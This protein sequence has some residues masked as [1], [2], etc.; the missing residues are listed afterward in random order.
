MTGR[1]TAITV[2]GGQAF[3]AKPIGLPLYTLMTLSTGVLPILAAWLTKGVLDELTGGAPLADLIAIGSGLVIVGVVS[4][5]LPHLLQYMKAE[6]ERE[7]G[8]VAQDRL[9]RAVGSLVG[10]G[11]FEDPQFLD[12]LRLAQQVSGTP[13]QLL[14]GA[15]GL[16]RAFIIILG[17]LGS[18]LLVSPVVMVL[19]LASGVPILV[20]EISLS[21]QRAR[22]MWKVSPAERREFFYSGLLADVQAAKE[23]RLFGVGDFLRQRMLDERRG[24]NAEKRIVDRRDVAVQTLLGFLAASLAGAGLLW[25]V[26]AAQNGTISPGDIALF[27]AAVAGVQAALAALASDVARSHHA[28][29]MFQHYVAVTRG[30]P[31]LPVSTRPRDVPALRSGIELRDVWFRYSAEHPWVLRGVNLHIDRG[32]ALGLVGLNGA[33][34]STIVKLLCRFYDPTRGA[35][36][37]DGVD[38]RE[39]DPG[40][41]R[42]RIGAVFQDY[43]TYDMTA[44]DNIALGDVARRDDAAA[45]QRAAEH[46]GIHEALSRL[47]WGYD[48]PLTRIFHLKADLTGRNGVTLSGGQWQRLALARALM[49]EQPDLMILDEPSSGLDPEAEYEIHE[50]LTRHRAGRTSLLISHRLWTVRDADVIVVLSG[51]KVVEQGVHS[52]LIANG[53]EYARLFTLQASG[54]QAHSG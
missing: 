16:V 41:L 17:F 54:Y 51:G 28:L 10:L 36:L 44:A 24:T 9:F 11:R 5:V 53:G 46:A 15:L 3:E 14:D 23:V 27:I 37:W 29:L 19:L 7:V 43:M 22:L 52:S 39:V 30:G 8:M 50:S 40:E 13:T 6:I 33:G 35:I 42:R 20:A 2:A 31:E 18:L 34:K 4:A 12:R 25:A 49:R 45:V 32:K 48:T 21:R 38:I 26:R 1:R 47:P